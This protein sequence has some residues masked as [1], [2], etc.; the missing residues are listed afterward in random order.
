[1]TYFRTLAV[2]WSSGRSWYRRAVHFHST[3]TRSRS[4]SCS[5]CR[6]RGYL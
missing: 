3:G 4:G 1:V 2:D 6:T 5:C